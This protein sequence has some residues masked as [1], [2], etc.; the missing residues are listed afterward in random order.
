MVID[1]MKSHH[2]NYWL[3][4]EALGCVHCIEAI[5]QICL[6]PN[7]NDELIV[8]NGLACVTQTV[9]HWPSDMVQ[10]LQLSMAYYIRTNPTVL[11]NEILPQMQG[12]LTPD[13]NDARQFLVWLWELLFPTQNYEGIDLKGVVEAN[14]IEKTNPRIWT[15]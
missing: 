8:K 3:I 14:D 12:R 2:V 10:S 1:V 13:P 7:P 5:D 6:I 9:S 11:V 4:A 15:N